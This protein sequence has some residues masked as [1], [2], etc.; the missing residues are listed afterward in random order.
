MQLESVELFLNDFSKWAY[1]QADIQAAALVGSWARHAATDRSD[2]DLVILTEDAQCYLR[3]WSWTWIFGEIRQAQLEDYGR[4][5]SVRVWYADG[6]EIE[7]GIAG[8]DWAADP[9]DE[10]TRRVLS[11]GMRILFERGPLLS[12]HLS[13][14]PGGS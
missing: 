9:L 6:R 10:G 3:D 5:T 2:V 12:Q 11:E 4:L 14:P 8:V 13:R 7:Y 1:G